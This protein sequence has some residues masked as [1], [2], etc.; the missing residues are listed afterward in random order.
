MKSLK[1]NG[2]VYP[3]LKIFPKLLRFR[4]GLRG[5]SNDAD[6]DAALEQ[7]AAVFGN[8]DTWSP[9]RSIDMCIAMHT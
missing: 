3:P 5:M 8:R 2:F 9:G 7:V 1:S 6:V 4:K